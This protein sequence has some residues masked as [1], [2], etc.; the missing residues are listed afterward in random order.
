MAVKIDPAGPHS[1]ALG[2]QA[3]P[4][5]GGADPTEP[6]CKATGAIHDAVTRHTRVIA[7]VERP[8][9]LASSAWSPEHQRDLAIRGDTT[10]R[11]A[12]DQRIHPFVPRQLGS[13][14][15]RHL[16]R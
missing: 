14:D 12:A 9:H 10:A 1:D 5:H 7:G 6:W 13:G 16:E 2:R 4:L 8:P 11:H 3:F 15:H